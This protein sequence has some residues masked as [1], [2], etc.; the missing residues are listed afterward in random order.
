MINN[1]LK[2]AWRSLRKN[3][4]FALL[5]IAGLGA[6]IAS[7]ALMLLW[8][9]DELSFDRFH[10]HTERL[11]SVLENQYYDDQVL[12]TPAT[13]GP[14]APALLEE[15]PEV[16]AA[17]RTDFGSRWVLAQGDKV[18]TER[19]L[20]TDPAFFDL[21]NFPVTRGDAR[22]ALSAPGN[23]ALSESL[24]RKLFGGADPVGQPVRINNK[25]DFRVAGVFRDVPGHSTLQFDWLASFRIFEQN[26]PWATR[27]ST[28]GLRTYVRLRPGADSAAVN[29]RLRHF[30]AG[31]EPEAAARPFLFASGDW[32]LRSKFTDGLQDGGRIQYVRLFALIAAIVLLIACINFMNLATARSER[33]AREVGVR[34]AVGAGRRSLVRQ[35]LAESMLMTALALPVALLTVLAA[36]PAFNRLVDKKLTLDPAD[37]V[38]PLGLLGLGLLV[39]LLAGSYPAFYL[40]SFRPL[41]VL[42]GL[43]SPLPRG[44][45]GAVS[46]R[47]GLVVLQFVIS[48]FL[49][50]GTLV[51]YRQVEHVKNRPLGFDRENVIYSA[52]R[53][54]VDEHFQAI[55]HDLLATGRVEEVALANQR[56]LE[57]GNNSDDFTWEGKRPDQEVLVT[58]EYVSPGY[59]RTAGIR[60][61]SGRDFNAA[62]PDAD[63]T[64][65]VINATMAEMMGP[66]DAVGK[67]LRAGETAYRV[68]GVVEDFLFNDMYGSP[69]P[70]V[71][72]CQPT[73]TN[74]VFIRFKSG[75]D[76][77][78][79]L[80]ATEPV[81]LRHN[82][83][84]PFDYKFLDEEFDRLFR[85]EMLVGKLARLFAGLAIFI[86][87]LG[88]FGLA[89][90]TTERRTKEIG[91]RKVLGATAASIVGLLGLEFL[92]LV[93]LAALFALPLAWW[94]MREWLSSY[95]YRIPLPWE[96]FLL[97]V[98]LA[99]LVAFVTVSLQS[100]RAAMANPAKS[101]KSE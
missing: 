8:V 66:G 38:L 24:A 76:V 21:F 46:I 29:A 87:C 58:N 65:V 95:A 90:Y 96:L 17:A 39:G 16:E 82:P 53:G 43:Q 101:L 77:R 49:I 5:N 55:R 41:A 84:F 85:S 19:G 99:L 97:A 68:E 26:N 91:I 18:F 71:L 30:I 13:P 36:L 2:I 93:L 88:L 25:D 74:L 70:V 4:T 69:G 3:K 10:A 34:K 12:T 73:S 64:A 57:M 75:Q 98:A 94:G 31:K 32:R 9:R 79:A 40:S 51:I 62:N 44:Q 54:A 59:L 86:C 20:L 47:R 27:W 11:F 15:M 83:G 14:L 100:V 78:A 33:R 89:A 1:D 35:F 45:G 28:N 81:F 37:P 7:A 50:I 72:F 92:R 48:I 23:I 6:G 80:A 52:K 22:L 56:L 67:T 60:L 61:R 63:S 42:R